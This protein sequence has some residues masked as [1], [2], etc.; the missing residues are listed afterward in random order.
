MTAQESNQEAILTVDGL[1]VNFHTRDGLVQA[2]RDVSFE[3]FPGESLGIVGESGCGKSVT[4]LSTMRLIDCPPGQ[5]MARKMTFQDT[6]LV[7]VP[8]KVLRKIRGNEISMI[9]QDPMTC[10]NPV[11]TVYKQMSETMKLH[12]NLG[13]DDAKERAIDLLGQVGI[14]AP[15]MRLKSYPHQLSGGIRQRVMIAMAIS[16]N[17]SILLADEPTTA[18]DVTIQDQILRLIKSLAQDLGMA[19]VLI[20]HNLGAVAGLSDRIIVMYAGQIVETVESNELFHNPLHPYTEGLLSSIPRVD[21]EEQKRL[22]SI[23]GKLPSPIFIPKGCSFAP[24]C[25]YAFD[26]C[27]EQPPTLKEASKGHFV[28]CWKVK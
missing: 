6:N 8:E 23:K 24:R 17:P 26:T 11:L 12:L 22:F 20:T 25:S 7:D 13:A 10:L 16:C 5:I 15:E 14:S 21:A 18:L 4:A 27:S 2:V 9:F 3:L 1:K 19:T 28:S